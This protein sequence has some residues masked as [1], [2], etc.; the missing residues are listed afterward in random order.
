MNRFITALLT[1]VCV[2]FTA[3]GFAGSDMAG[4]DMTGHDMTPSDS[5]SDKV[6]E[7]FH[8]SMV[9]GYMLAYYLM[10][11][12]EQKTGE[13]SS[14][15]AHGKKEMDKPHHIMVYIMDKNH[16][17]V[18]KG[19]VGF[20]ITNKEGIKQKAMGMNMSGGFGTTVD[21]KGKGVYAIATKVVMGEVKLM[22]KFEYE[23]K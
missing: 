21:M 18:H 10:D 14:H 9:K 5:K 20:L 16:K 6:G 22:D 4:H 23:T 11:L 13:V 1:I 8:E 3:A 15:A 2:S 7:L 19:K 12:R 17:P